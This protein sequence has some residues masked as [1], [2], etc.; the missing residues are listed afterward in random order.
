MNLFGFTITRAK[1]EKYRDGGITLVGHNAR[2]RNSNPPP[3]PKP[4]FPS[5]Q[6]PPFRLPESSKPAEDSTRAAAVDKS[7][8]WIKI[9]AATPL[10]RKLQLINKPAG[11]ATY[12]ELTHTGEQ[13]WTHYALMPTF[14]DE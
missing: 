8:P 2:P 11:V 6:V 3:Y 10:R 9:N 14:A 13:F 1:R 5:G 4:P 7:Y 12:G